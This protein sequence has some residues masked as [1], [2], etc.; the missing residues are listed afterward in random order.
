MSTAILWFRQDLRLSDNPALAHALSHYERVI[1]LFI[2]AP[3]ESAPW[4]PGAAS[5]WWLH[6]SLAA[7]DRSLRERGTRLVLRN[8]PSLDALQQLI[9]ES[10][11]QAVLW[12][13]L[14]EPVH[15]ARDRQIKQTLREQGVTVESFNAVL[16]FEPWQV[17]KGNGDPYRVFTPYWKACQQRG[18]TEAT[19]MAPERLPPLSPSLGSEKL[20]TLGLLPTL[21]WDSGFSTLWQ[22]GEAGAHQQLAR[23]LDDALH[24]YESGRDIP[25]EANT[26][27]LSPALHFGEIGPRQLVA[28]ITQFAARHHRAGVI[29][30]AEAWQRQLLWREFAHT[31]LYHFP[32]TSEQPFDK[33][34]EHFSWAK[35]Y[36]GA[37]QVWQR[38]KT[39]IPI[40]DAGMREL[41]HTGWMHNRVRMIVASL[42]T[43]NLLIPWQEG[44]RWFWDT[45]LDAD[46]ANNSFGW[47]WVAGSG[48]DAAP[49]FRIFNPV[50]QGEKFDPHGRYVRRWLPELIALPDKYIHKPWQAPQTILSE[51]GV[52]LDEHYPRPMLDLKASRERALERFKKIK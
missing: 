21:P 17:V 25:A 38:G 12:N 4:Q 22:P 11:A 27:R 18:L 2:H 32:H 34:F 30:N 6:H 7:L 16:L 48:N 20:D 9:H 31:L 10:Q 49:Y 19:V 37:L 29:S 14:Y 24:H 28:A 40:V 1:P 45:L 23:F 52:V 39:G 44:A 26:S 8:S 33:R 13:R 47:Q 5:R 46:L 42:L 51:A 36:Q 43:K 41:W 3:D 15:I 35:N 50:L